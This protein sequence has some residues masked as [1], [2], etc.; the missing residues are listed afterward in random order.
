L[1]EPIEAST[2]EMNNVPQSHISEM[3]IT[4]SRLAS[5]KEGVI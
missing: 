1:A 4:T 2:D 5:Q 3:I